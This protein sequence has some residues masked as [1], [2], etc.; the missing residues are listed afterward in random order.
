LNKNMKYSRRNSFI[1][2]D[3]EK[4]AIRKL[5]EATTASA[6]GSYSQPL[7]WKE[8]TISPCEAS[9]LEA[10][11]EGEDNIV[12]GS[13]GLTIDADEL[14]DM[15]GLSEEDEEARIRSLH[16]GASM[17]KEQE[18]PTIDPICLTCV[19]DALGKYEDRANTVALK[20]MEIVADGEVTASEFGSAITTILSQLGG[21]SMFDLIPISQALYGCVEKCKGL[22]DIDISMDI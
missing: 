13:E 10:E 20:I 21:I 19:E 18:M 9:A 22:T 5:Y 15:I 17:V 3:E 8:E 4:K 11:V 7:D 16:K 1:L 14:M 6:S 12:D 2:L